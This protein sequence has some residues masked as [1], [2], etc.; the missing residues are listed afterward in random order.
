MLDL[1]KHHAEEGG[2]GRLQVRVSPKQPEGLVSITSPPG[3]SLLSSRDSLEKT[4][5]LGKIEGRKRE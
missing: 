5:I 3:H 1:T 4:L 2:A